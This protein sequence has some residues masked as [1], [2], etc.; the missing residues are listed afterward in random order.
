MGPGTST[1]SKIQS[2]AEDTSLTE[3]KVAEIIYLYLTYCCEEVL[4]DGRSN[5]I[6]GMMS[7]NENNELQLDK[8]KF[9]IITCLLNKTD[10]KMIRRIIEQGNDNTIF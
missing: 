4:V 9:G 5:T 7:L 2:I 8:K 1:F 6:F 3:T 10:L